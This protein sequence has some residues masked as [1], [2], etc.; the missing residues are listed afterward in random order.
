MN[1]FLDEVKNCLE[2]LQQ[3]GSILYPTDTVWGLGCDATNSEAVEKL[4]TIKDRPAHKSMIVLMADEKQ[5]MQYVSQVDLAVFEYL[6]NSPR[7]TTV[8]YEGAIGL[9]E[10]LLAEDGSIG[11]RI[12]KDPFCR[13]LIK[14]SN[15]PLVSTSANISGQ[16]TPATFREIRPEI[17]ERVDYIV[18]YRREESAPA[19]PSS[20]IRWKDGNAVVLR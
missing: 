13:H 12:V 14:R 10:N 11:I 5:V 8:I 15:K 4:Y 9:P 17:L 18:K 3:G 20:I 6:Q 16:P 1:D 7:P 19:A 2:T